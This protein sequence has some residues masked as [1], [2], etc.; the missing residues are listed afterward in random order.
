MGPIAS[1]RTGSV[2]AAPIQKRR[3]KS[4]SSGLGPAS[5][6][7]TPIGSSAMPQLGQS[8]GA[9]LHDLGA[10]GTGVKRALGHRFR[11]GKTLQISGRVTLEFPLA[12]RRAKI[13]ALSGVFGDMPGARS[14]H[15][16]AADGI[17]RL[18]VIF[19]R[20]RELVAAPRAA[21]AIDVAVVLVRGLVRFR[22]DGHGADRISHENRLLA[23]VLMRMRVRGHGLNPFCQRGLVDSHRFPPP[24]ILPVP[25]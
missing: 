4:T 23:F 6:A 25:A 8:E 18:K 17:F 13:E 24:C 16:H 15:G 22:I 12:T 1:A 20:G 10:H 2:S 7:G 11:L 19:R 9:L 3:V 21:E 5:A 14:R